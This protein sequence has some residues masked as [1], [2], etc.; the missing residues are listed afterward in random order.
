MTT[1]IAESTD[2]TTPCPSWCTLRPGHPADSIHN[3]GRESRGHAGPNF[4][5]FLYA[6]SDEFTDA[7]G[8]QLI[9][10]SL[11]ADDSE[12]AHDQLRKLSR[13]ALDAAAWLEAHQ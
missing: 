3:D 11:Y 12:L 8:E 7:P 2:S 5:E 10:M 9:E 4:G 1:T 13:N 6:G